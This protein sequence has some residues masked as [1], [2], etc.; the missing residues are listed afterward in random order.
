[1]KNVFPVSNAGYPHNV[2]V[3]Q[4]PFKYYNGNKSLEISKLQRCNLHKFEIPALL[5]PHKDTFA[6]YTTK[7]HQFCKFEEA[8][9]RICILMSKKLFFVSYRV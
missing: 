8:S 3:N 7:R 6:V 9:C 1:M 5:L 2:P 4:I